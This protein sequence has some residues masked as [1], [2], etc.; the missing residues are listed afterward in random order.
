MKNITTRLLL[1]E[2]DPT[3]AAIISDTLAGNGADSG[4]SDRKSTRLNSSH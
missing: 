3:V 2:D 1:I 4:G